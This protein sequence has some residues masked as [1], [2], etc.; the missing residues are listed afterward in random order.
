LIWKHGKNSEQIGIPT[1]L[2]YGLWSSSLK[3]LVL[4]LAGLASF[5]APRTRLQAL[6]LATATFMAA[7]GFKHFGGSIRSF[8]T[9]TDE[10]KVLLSI[11]VQILG[12]LIY[13]TI[14]RPSVYRLPV[15]VAKKFYQQCRCRRGCL[16]ALFCGVVP[17]FW[18][19]RGRLATA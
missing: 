12:G 11:G 17:D 10:T 5:L 7:S 14:W 6:T 18:C 1:S 19:Y 9:H 2:Q 15:S 13:G 4:W 3:A 8:S 16:P